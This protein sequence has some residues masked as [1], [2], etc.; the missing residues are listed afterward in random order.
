MKLTYTGDPGRYY[1]SLGLE[2]EPDKAYDLDTDPG[3]GRWAAPKPAAKPTA[4]KKEGSD[5]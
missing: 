5:A 3:D 4:N 2:P 1:P